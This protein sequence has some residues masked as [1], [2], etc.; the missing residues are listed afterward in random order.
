[1]VR[2]GGRMVGWFWC[3]MVRGRCWRVI[4]GRGRVVWLGFRILWGAFI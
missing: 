1:V 2:S 3:R 4:W